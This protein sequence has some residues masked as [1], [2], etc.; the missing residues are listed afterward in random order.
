MA[1]QDTAVHEIDVLRWLLDDE[2]VSVQVITPRATG[3]RFDHLRD[4]QL[5]YFE[6]A[7]GVRIDLEVRS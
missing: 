1:A 7:N 6:T 5:M 2:I 3:K 4:P